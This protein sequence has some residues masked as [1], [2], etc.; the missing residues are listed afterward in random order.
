M[1]NLVNFTKKKIIDGV[2]NY[3]TA[4]IMPGFIIDSNLNNLLDSA[5]VVIPNVTDDVFTC[6]DYD[7]VLLEDV[8]SNTTFYKV[9]NKKK[10]FST[11]E[12]PFKYT[13]TLNLVSLTKHLETIIVPAMGT[14]TI[15]KFRSVATFIREQAKRYFKS[16]DGYD[17]ID[18]EIPTE[19]ENKPMPELTL[20]KQTLRERLDALYELSGCIS[21]LEIDTV[22]DEDFNVREGYVLKYIDLSSRKGALDTSLIDNMEFSQS[23]EDYVDNVDN[24]ME[25]VIGQSYITETIPYK[26][27]QYVVSSDNAQLITSRPIQ[28]IKSVY[29]KGNLVVTVTGNMFRNPLGYD[30][31]DSYT[32]QLSTNSIKSFGIDK[33]GFSIDLSRYFVLPEVYASLEA[34][35]G[36]YYNYT[37][38]PGGIYK[39]NTVVW[40]RGS[41]VIEGFHKREEVSLQ[42]LFG[43]G[44]LAIEH[45]LD[46]AIY[47]HL[48]EI[49]KNT[50]LSELR[51]IDE[52]GFYVWHEKSDISYAHISYDSYEKNWANSCFEITYKP[53]SDVRITYTKNDRLEHPVTMINN[54]ASKNIDFN[55]YGKQMVE[56]LNQLGNDA[57]S[58]DGHKKNNQIIT[59]GHTFNDYVVTQLE[60]VRNQEFDYFK[61][62]MTKFNSNRNIYSILDREIRYYSLVNDAETII[63]HEKKDIDVYMSFT[64]GDDKYPIKTMNPI[65]YVPS[66]AQFTTTLSDDST[67]TG[68]SFPTYTY[69]GN[70][71]VY[72]FEFDNNASFG[73]ICNT[74]YYES[75]R[76]A[77]KAQSLSFM[78][79]LKYVD[80]NGEFEGLNIKFYESALHQFTEPANFA[81]AFPNKNDNGF[82]D[83]SNLIYEVDDSFHKDN[84]E[85][86]KYSV[87]FHLQS[88]KENL[89]L[90]DCVSSIVG[91][92]IY[93]YGF[94]NDINRY[95]IP[96]I[97]SDPIDTIRI[98][99]NYL[100]FNHNPNYNSYIL[101]TEI[102]NAMLLNV[103][104]NALFVRIRFSYD[105]L[106]ESVGTTSKY[107]VSTEKISEDDSSVT[108]KNTYNDGSTDIKVM[109]KTLPDYPAEIPG[110]SG[111]GG[112]SG[113][114]GRGIVSIAKTSEI[115]ESSTHGR[116]DIFTITYTDGTTSTFQVE[117][118][119]NGT[120]GQDGADGEQGKSAYEIA[121]ENGFEGTEE[122]WLE[123]LKGEQG[124]PGVSI[125]QTFVNDNGE[126]IIVFTD[127]SIKNVGQITNNPPIVEIPTIEELLQETY[128]NSTYDGGIWSFVTNVG[129]Y[130][131]EGFEG[132]DLNYKTVEITFL[133]FCG[134]NPNG[135]QLTDRHIKVVIANDAMSNYA[136]DND[137][138]GLYEGTY[139]KLAL[140][141][142]F[143]TDNPYNKR[144]AYELD[145]YH[146]VKATYG[147]R[148]LNL[149]DG[150]LVDFYQYD[151]TPNTE[152]K[153]TFAI[154]KD[155]TR[156]YPDRD[157]ETY[158]Y[159]WLADIY[160]EWAS[161]MIYDVNDNATFERVSKANVETIDL[162]EYIR[163]LN[164]NSN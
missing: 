143:K 135:S 65:N 59:V 30:K 101:A 150:E 82:L 115:P 10:A 47:E 87:N 139:L 144:Y 127:G 134:Y 126:L 121:V 160:S 154:D 108:Y 149:V 73:T 94:T 40:K 2:E 118:G 1:A 157:S 28:D 17:L 76:D 14:T 24:T 96:I 13:W 66:Y 92:D 147:G 145:N 8:G 6:D 102:G 132:N 9:G 32:E 55:A 122:E 88:T 90:L 142:L 45:L 58:F 70:T 148:E 106:N 138:T 16:D 91:R 137:D 130:T 3:P 48:E 84:R 146:I 15:K 112:G 133:N 56:K 75:N 61:G 20:Q 164:K 62:V 103:N 107:I 18:I 72:T 100:Q 152:L 5:L 74:S 81:L 99:G 104:S 163:Q 38:I 57:I 71:F 37:N 60:I 109:N 117:N 50:T 153:I 93:V 159:T 31:H 19:L 136:M 27:T 89:L 124:K 161:F 69:S 26:S 111:T 120:P 85:H 105:K 156:D 95:N 123:S 29:F 34:L 98:E 49:F 12:E 80:D 11:F 21:K 64:M 140:N 36:Q 114:P 33:I 53:I 78:E 44:K 51:Y 35:S 125:F 141:E 151:K 158:N 22:E 97:N 68:Y 43:N 110:D 162:V 42:W 83:G 39:N 4:P 52:N 129:D 77:K 116:I 79:Y 86:I 119:K 131:I 23:A 67:I 54:Q 113:E 63:R 46:S 128:A 41:N 155:Y 7:L 25:Q